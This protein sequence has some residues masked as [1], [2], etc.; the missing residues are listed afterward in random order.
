MGGPT[1]E[2]EDY[3]RIFT[4]A[5]GLDVPTSPPNRLG[6]ALPK[7]AGGMQPFAIIKPQ[8]ILANRNASAEECPAWGRIARQTGLW[9]AINERE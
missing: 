4:P 3:I 9:E 6:K 5:N 1:P 2:A 7:P 8:S